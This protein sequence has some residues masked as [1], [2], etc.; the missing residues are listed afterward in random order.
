MYVW[1]ERSDNT[2]YLVSDRLRRAATLEVAL[3]ES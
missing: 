1:V 3:V 2:F